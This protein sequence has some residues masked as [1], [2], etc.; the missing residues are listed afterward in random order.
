[1]KVCVRLHKCVVC[2]CLCVLWVGLSLIVFCVRIWVPLSINLVNIRLLRGTLAA[3][4]AK[5]SRG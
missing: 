4:H 5:W 3:E 2:M 1:M